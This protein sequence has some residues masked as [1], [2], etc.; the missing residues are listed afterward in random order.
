MKLLLDLRADALGAEL[1]SRSDWK[2][3]AH[4]LHAFPDGESLLRIDAD[5]R[6]MQVAVLTDLARPEQRALRVLLAA[7]ALRCCSTT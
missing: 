6:G 2:Q 1:A 5:I 4:E 7:T 3:L